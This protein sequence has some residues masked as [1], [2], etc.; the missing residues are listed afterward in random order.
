MGM[1]IQ[2]QEVC[3]ARDLLQAPVLRSKRGQ[4]DGEINETHASDL[5]EVSFSVQAPIILLIKA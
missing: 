2:K 5:N 3:Q 4:D 1:I